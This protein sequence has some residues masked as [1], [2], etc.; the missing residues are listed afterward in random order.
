MDLLQNFPKIANV[1]DLRYRWSKLMK[2]LE[3]TEIPILVMQHSTPK[4]VIFPFDKVKRLIK[5]K[6]MTFNENP[7]LLIDRLAGSIKV[8]KRFKKLSVDKLI[9]RAKKEYFKKE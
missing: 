4:A 5:N 1:T 8:P 7:F 2:E 6:A 3:K 9:E